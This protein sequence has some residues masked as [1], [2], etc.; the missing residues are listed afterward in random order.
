MW[1]FQ[2]VLIDMAFDAIDSRSNGLISMKV[3][4]VHTCEQHV[5]NLFV[6]TLAWCFS[7]HVPVFAI[8]LD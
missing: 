1:C 3:H 5:Q 7:C 6:L 8:V 4:A 2:K